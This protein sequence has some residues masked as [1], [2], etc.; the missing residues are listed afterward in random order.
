MLYCICRDVAFDLAQMAKTIE[1]SMSDSVNLLLSGGIQSLSLGG[2]AEPMSSA[3]PLTTPQ[4][5][6]IPSLPPLSLPVPPSLPYPLPLS[7][8]SLSP[9]SPPLPAPPLPS[10]W[11]EGSGGPP[12]E[13]FEILDCCRWV[14]AHSGMQKGVCKCVF[15]GRAMKIFWPQSRGG[16]RPPCPPWIRHWTKCRAV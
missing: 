3:L 15:L 8:P 10:P 2:G 14:L 12:P 16:D 6:F 7:F 4:P 5:P 9:P 1:E 13:N 11:R